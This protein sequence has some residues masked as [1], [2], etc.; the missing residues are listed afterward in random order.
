MIASQFV[1]TGLVGVAS[2]VMNLNMMQVCHWL[3]SWS[4]CHFEAFQVVH[5]QH[6]IPGPLYPT[7][8]GSFELLPT[9]T[10]LSNAYI[11]VMILGVLEHNT[12]PKTVMMWWFFSA[13]GTCLR[14]SQ[15]NCYR[16]KRKVVH[17]RV[18]AEYQFHVEWPGLVLPSSYFRCWSMVSRWWWKCSFKKITVS[19]QELHNPEN[20]WK[21]RAANLC[22][23]LR[24]RGP[25]TSGDRS[26]GGV[27]TDSPWRCCQRH[28]CLGI[29]GWHEEAKRWLQHLQHI[30][31]HLSCRRWRHHYQTQ[32]RWLDW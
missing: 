17:Q 23:S 14:L 24:G 6:E 3:P 21:H 9:M 1:G 4:W 15:D 10:S 11:V 28:L 29:Y 7:L 27:G 2:D 18:S 16:P 30:C 31:H 26:F 5:Q 12:L 13:L 20:Q 8:E 32:G 19:S 25:G 22:S